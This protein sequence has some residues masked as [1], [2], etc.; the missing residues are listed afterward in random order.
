MF[1]Q[2]I[3]F[4][5]ASILLTFSPGPDI[6]YVLSQSLVGGYKKGMLIAL[7]LVSGIIIHTSLVAFGVSLIIKNSELLFWSIKI[8]GA[9]YLLFLAYKVYSSPPQSFSQDKTAVSK[10]LAFSDFKTG[11]IMNILNP[12]VTIFF[13]AFFPGFLWDTEK[14]VMMQFYI[15]GGVFMLQAFIIFSLVAL[16]SDQLSKILFKTSQSYSFL[17]WFQI[18][19]FVAI[20]ILILL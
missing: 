18:F 6:I 16:L 2:L 7:G 5:I 1:E 8:A 11:F 14:D 15:L 13:L 4:L 20:A 10:K 12:K 19:T 3:P 17:K 9:L